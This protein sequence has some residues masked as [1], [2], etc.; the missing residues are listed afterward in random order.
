MNTE[1]VGKW[2]EDDGDNTL[3]ITYPLTEDSVVFDVGGYEGRWA[4]SIV[5]KYNPHV[6][7]FEPVK[8]F[9]EICVERFKDSPKVYVNNHGLSDCNAE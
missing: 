4:G 9:Y 8:K 7:V 6:F 1:N 3:L 2:F 5:N